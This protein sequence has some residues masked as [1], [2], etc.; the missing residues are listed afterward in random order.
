MLDF[1]KL[2]YHTNEV[3]LEYERTS[4]KVRSGLYG[5]VWK[6]EETMGC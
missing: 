1:S 3:K 2:P 6:C 4:L 5:N